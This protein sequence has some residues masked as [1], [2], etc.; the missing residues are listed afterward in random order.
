MEE[1]YLSEKEKTEHEYEGEKS[2]ERKKEEGN[3][4]LNLPK[5]LEKEENINKIMEEDKNSIDDIKDYDGVGDDDD[6]DDYDIPPYSKEDDRLST[7]ARKGSGNDIS[8]FSYGFFNLFTT[9]TI[10]FKDKYIIDLT[11]KL[12]SNV[13]RGKNKENNEE[14]IFK[15][16]KMNQS[17]LLNE[18]EILIELY[19]IERVPKIVTIG[20]SGPY[21]ILAMN[22]IGPSLQDCL[23]K[24]DGK[25]TLGTTLKISLQILNIVKQIHEK[26]VA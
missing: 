17:N 16:E 24:C 9:T 6:Y 18:A 23:E 20:S 2:E 21:Y 4:S 26:G 8:I 11:D 13:F 19:N 12:A 5:H 22:Y 15:F 14:L 3:Q 10:T 25:F 1:R 7:K